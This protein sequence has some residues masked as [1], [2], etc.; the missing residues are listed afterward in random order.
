MKPFEEFPTD[1]SPIDFE[2]IIAEIFKKFQHKVKHYEVVHNVKEKSENAEY[3]IDIK[4]TFEFLGV[5]FVVLVEC[6]KYNSGIKR[7]LIQILNDKVKEL[8]AHKG[9]LVSSSGYQKGAIEYAK[10]HGIALIRLMD[11]VLT[12]EAKSTF[13][14]KVK[15]P[16]WVDLPKYALFWMYSIN[17]STIGTTSLDSDYFQKFEEEIF[18][19]SEA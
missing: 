11:G 4:V 9:I 2:L 19:I 18:K 10:K 8:G 3:Q 13:P 6:K 1:I 17:E 5:D 14:S 7:E 16:E 12:Y 15:I